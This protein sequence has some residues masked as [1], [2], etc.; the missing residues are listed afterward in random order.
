MVDFKK[1]TWLYGLLAGI[2]ALIGL[3]IPWGSVELG[4]GITQYGWLGGLITNVDGDWV[5]GN[6][7]NLWTLA[8]TATSITIL[9]IYSINT[10]RGK[11]FKWDWLMYI[12]TGIIL[13]IFPILTLVLEGTTNATPIGSI[14]IIIAGVVAIIAFVLD[15]FVK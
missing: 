2:L 3:I 13:L 5:G 8:L 7:L 11:E 9:L 12:L 4:F 1:D 6:G 10:W 14:I 15:K